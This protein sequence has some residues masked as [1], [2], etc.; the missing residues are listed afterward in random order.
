[1]AQGVR[2]GYGELFKTFPDAHRKD[3][4]ALTNFFKAKT[5]VGDAVIKQMVG[6]F[7]T[8]AAYGDFDGADASSVEEIAPPAALLRQA[9]QYLLRVDR[10]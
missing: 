9:Y 7:K 8:L 4:E 1:M 6:T 3:S 5:S 2:A 10:A